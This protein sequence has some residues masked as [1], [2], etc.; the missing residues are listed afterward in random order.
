MLITFWKYLLKK[1]RFCLEL[2]KFN[3]VNK[4]NTCKGN[5][6]IIV[7]LSVKSGAMLQDF[8]SEYS[9]NEAHLN[10]LVLMLL[11]YITQRI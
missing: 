10:G 11:N 6:K 7:L 8:I 3:R 1:L 5:L 9:M 2:K 4:L